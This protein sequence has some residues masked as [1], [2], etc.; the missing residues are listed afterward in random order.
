MSTITIT[1]LPSIL[2]CLTSTFL[3]LTFTKFT[4]SYYYH[5]SN[6]LIDF[7]VIFYYFS[8]NHKTKNV[9]KIDEITKKHTIVNLNE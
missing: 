5:T 4:I 1:C 3:R 7:S 8:R 6:Y 2:T 9:S